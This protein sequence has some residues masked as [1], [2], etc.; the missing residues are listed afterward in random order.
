MAGNGGKAEG[1]EV[2]HHWEAALSAKMQ[3]EAAE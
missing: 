2:V 1:W 3:R